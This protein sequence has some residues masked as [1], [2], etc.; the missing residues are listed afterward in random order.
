MSVLATLSSSSVFAQP[1]QADMALA[2]RLFEDAERLMAEGNAAAA[3]PKYAESQARDPQLGTLL[4]LA[5]CQER[6]GK[7]A[8]AWAGY[9]AAAEIA[10]RR[11]AVGG[12]EP[13][14]QIARA[15]AAALEPKL[16]T[17]VVH[18]ADA[19]P[20]SLE[21]RRDGQPLGRALWGTILPVDP[22]RYT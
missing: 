14:E 6:V 16:S 7:L 11:N 9:K 20:A 19:N 3:C 17:V 10:A 21:I 12:N 2:I 15:R 5:D 1:T 22:G 13:R 4:H 18:V 8:S